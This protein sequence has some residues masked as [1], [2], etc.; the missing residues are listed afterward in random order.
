MNSRIVLLG[1]EFYF[2]ATEIKFVSSGRPRIQT[3][4]LHHTLSL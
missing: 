1:T 3:A 2:Q 4:Y